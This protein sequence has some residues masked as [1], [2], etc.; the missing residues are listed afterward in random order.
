MRG[1][2]VGRVCEW[3]GGNH[4]LKLRANPISFSSP[5]LLP[6]K[7]ASCSGWFL[8]VLFVFRCALLKV[9]VHS[10][11]M[12]RSGCLRGTGTAKSRLNTLIFPCGLL[13][14]ISKICSAFSLRFSHSAAG[15]NYGSRPPLRF[16]LHP[17]NAP[18]FCDWPAT[19]C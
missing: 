11:V 5:D 1:V 19:R 7:H 10:M 9:N 18:L 15:G 17:L 4:S 12:L 3:G 2:G 6:L 16:L 13:P 14:T 8:H